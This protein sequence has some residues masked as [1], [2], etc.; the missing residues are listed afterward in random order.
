MSTNDKFWVEDPCILFRE[1]AIFPAKDMTKPE[2]LN[3]LTRLVIISA[4]VMYYMKYENWF[5]FLTLS[6]L[7]II[8]FNY[9]EG[10]EKFK[11]QLKEDESSED[12][13]SENLVEN[14][15]I[16]PTMTSGDFHQTVIAPS[17]AEE[18]QINPSATDSHVGEIYTEQPQYQSG[19]D[20]PLRQK[21]YPYNQYLTRTNLLP[22]DEYTI[23]QQCGGARSAREFQNNAWTR[24]AIAN[25]ENMSRL[26][27]KK[28]NA[29]F[30]HSRCHDVISP[31]SSY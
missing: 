10:E 16:V 17:F 1:L 26:H 12:N 5:P 3:A 4:I 9:S 11:K 6:I 27:K 7:L 24:H 25:R 21:S 18:W 8:V 23:H 31:Y 2:K 20:T 14:F 28:L 15:S 22:S 13:S 30:R 29:R 19:Y